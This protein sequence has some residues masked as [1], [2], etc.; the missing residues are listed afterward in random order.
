VCR[1]HHPDGLLL[2]ILNTSCRIP[3]T[4]SM[5]VKSSL[6]NTI[7]NRDASLAGPDILATS[8]SLKSLQMGGDKVARK[9][10][11]AAATGWADPSTPAALS[12]QM[13]GALF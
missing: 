12:H 3:F 5:G 8:F 1:E 7:A 4:N 6:R 10:T 11:D 2:D 9:V 13:I